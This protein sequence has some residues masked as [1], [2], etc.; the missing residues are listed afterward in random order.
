MQKRFQVLTL[1]CAITAGLMGSASV[2]AEPTYKVGATATGIPF[3]FLDIKTGTT[4]GMMIDAAQAIGRAG[5]FETQ[6]EQ[7]PFAAL[8]PSLTSNK[9]DL[10]SAGMLKTPERAKVVQFSD[11]IYSYGEGLIVNADDDT[12]YTTMDDLKGEVVGAQVGTV[13]I[14]SLNKHGGFKE[15][16]SYDSIPDMIRDLSL[17]RIKAA[18]GDR[19]VIAYQLAQGKGPNVKL[20]TTYVPV[21]MGDVCLVVRQGDTEKLEQ[22]NKGIAAIKADGTLQR[23]IEKWNL[24]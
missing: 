15:V 11:P 5:G 14:D 24:N 3:T 22:I 16:R 19:P 4:Q 17:G 1:I 6:V 9:I 23:I 2:V 10:I 18:F 21:V 12:V 7:S 8:I 13:F 20:S